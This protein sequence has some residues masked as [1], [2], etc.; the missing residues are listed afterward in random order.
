MFFVKI[1][2]QKSEIDGTGLFAD[3]DIK[4]GDIIW[5]LDHNKINS[6]LKFIDKSIL[7]TLEEEK[8]TN[9][10]LEVLI[11]CIYKDGKFIYY[12]D[13]NKYINHSLEPNAFMDKDLTVVAIKDIKAGEEITENYNSYEKD[14]FLL[15]WYNKYN[16]EL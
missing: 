5:K 2:T 3:Q 4:K 1:K 6:T 8:Q 11:Y 14:D 10:I 13:E 12:L 16:V 9:Q 7:S 15:H